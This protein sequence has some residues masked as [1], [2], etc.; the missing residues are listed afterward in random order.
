VSYDLLLTLDPA[1]PRAKVQEIVLSLR[2]AEVNGSL[3]CLIS[4]SPGT[5]IAVDFAE[6]L[7]SGISVSLAYGGSPEEPEAAIEAVALIAQKTEAV[8]FDP[9]I[10]EHL[11]PDQLSLVLSNWEA[12]NLH[13]LETYS[14]G[15]HFVRELADGPEGRVMLEAQRTDSQSADNY[16]SIASAF[17]RIGKYRKSLRLLKRGLSI[18]PD[19][20]PALHLLGIIYLNLERPGPASRAFKRYL[21]IQP[22]AHEVSELL[23]H[24]RLSSRSLGSLWR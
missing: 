10:G 5:L 16:C 8:V 15:F 18:T 6:D 19:H 3:G 17:G 23:I 4:R 11:R 22:E 13:A 14:D 24:A 7:V 9:Q 20:L 12:G 2:G 21:D 1:V